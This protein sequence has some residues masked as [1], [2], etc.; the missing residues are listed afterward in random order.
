[1]TGIMEF[2]MKSSGEMDSNTID[3]LEHPKDMS[4]KSQQ[5]ITWFD[6]THQ[7]SRVGVPHTTS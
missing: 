4:Y 3:N 5:E 7:V 1:M 2:H 6:S